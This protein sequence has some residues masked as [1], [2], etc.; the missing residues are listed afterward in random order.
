MKNKDKKKDYY[1]SQQQQAA[2]AQT[3]ESLRYNMVLWVVYELLTI[4]NVGP[5]GKNKFDMILEIQGRFTH[6]SLFLMLP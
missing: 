4:Q 5:S 6:E 1:E 2:K 3:L